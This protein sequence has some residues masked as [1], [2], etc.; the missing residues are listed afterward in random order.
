M[1]LQDEVRTIVNNCSGLV[2][3]GKLLAI[4]GSSGSGK[5]SLLDAICCR[6]APGLMA[7]G[8]IYFNSQR[9]TPLL[10]RDNVAYVQQDDRLLPNLTVRETFTYAALMRLPTTLTHEQK[11]QRVDSVLTEL[12]LS[13]VAGS[14]IGGAHVR[15]ISGGERRRVSIGVQLLKDPRVLLLDEPTSG[16]DSFTAARVMQILVSLAKQRSRTVI[17]TLHQPSS[18]IFAML[19]QVML[20]SQGRSTFFGPGDTLVKYFETQGFPCPPFV[21]P[22]DHY[23]VRPDLVLCSVWFGDGHHPTAACVACL[24]SRTGRDQ[25]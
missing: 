15:G 10:V 18:A 25:R 1:R 6:A 22:L 17:C 2:S 24:S 20:M 23:M 4:M 9:A 12:G 13:H 5:T 14:K 21:N 3:P 8:S 16:L 11:L 7:E 19:D